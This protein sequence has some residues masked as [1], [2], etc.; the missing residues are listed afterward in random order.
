MKK[1]HFNV[2]L[3]QNQHR[4]DPVGYFAKDWLQDKGLLQ[5]SGTH[6]TDVRTFLERRGY[7]ES[8]RQA[9]RQAWLY[10]FRRHFAAGR[11]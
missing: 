8:S 9:A 5:S 6:W 7:T 1:T 4:E 10:R 2:F 3:K 11:R